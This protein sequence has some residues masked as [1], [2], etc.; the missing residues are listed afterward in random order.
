MGLCQMS[1][2]ANRRTDANAVQLSY[3][4]FMDYLEVLREKIRRL[5]VEIAEIQRLNEQYRR[6]GG[7]EAEAEMAYRRRHERLQAIQQELAQL[8]AFGRKAPSGEEK[9]EQHRSHPHFV[10]KA[11]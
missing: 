5:R 1:G 7:N 3:P 9:T 10:N 2:L 4:D 11:S 6:Q 8:A